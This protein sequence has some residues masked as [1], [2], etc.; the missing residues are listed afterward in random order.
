VP[1][2]MPP[3][4][5]YYV[6]GINGSTGASLEEPLT[7][8]EVGDAARTLVEEQQDEARDRVLMAKS[9]RTTQPGYRAIVGVDERELAET[10]WGVIFSKG[11]HPG[12]KVALQ[13]LLD[14]RQK[15]AG[16]LFKVYEGDDGYRI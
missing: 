12:L 4:D 5:L 2:E 1:Q 6:N 13:P 16:D 15:D 14:H 9:I 10:G 3:E 7:P 8:Q 11:A